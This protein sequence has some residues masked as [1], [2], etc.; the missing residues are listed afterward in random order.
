[1]KR[2]LLMRHAKSSWD[3]ASLADFDRPLA[4]RGREA[5]PRMGREMA[6][7]GWL[8]ELALVSPA[9]R[10]RQTWDL[11]AAELA[12]PPPAHFPDTL[13]DASTESILAEVQQTP[14]TVKTLLVLGH[15][16]GLEELAAELAGDHSDAG[17]LARLGEKFP[18]AA[19]ARFRF[20][21]GWAK[22]GAGVARLSHFMRP[23][24]LH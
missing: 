22:L 11:V 24:D 7:R 8:P 14:E 19:L 18:T 1:M 6:R 21:G 23:K 12:A 13:Y 2:L 4:P 17:G 10:T 15:N 20:D 5:A 9:A 3:D 16:P